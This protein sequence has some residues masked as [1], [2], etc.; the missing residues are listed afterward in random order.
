MTI[1]ALTQAIEKRGFTV[2]LNSD[3]CSFTVLDAAGN[4]VPWP[5]FSVGKSGKVNDVALRSYHPPKVA[6]LNE[7]ETV[8]LFGDL[9][10][11]HVGHPKQADNAVRE[12]LASI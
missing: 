4:N 11:K 7:H 5:T 2:S 3:G 1:Q 9:Y 8:V 10:A 12:L 6:D